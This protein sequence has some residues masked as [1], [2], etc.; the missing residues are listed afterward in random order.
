MTN[1]LNPI[2]KILVQRDKLSRDEAEMQ[3]M[4]ARAEVAAGEDP[5]NVLSDFFGLEPDYIFDLLEEGK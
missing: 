3:L 4:D 2:V 1:S 5:E